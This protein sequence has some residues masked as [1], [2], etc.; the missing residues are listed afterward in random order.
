MD[1]LNRPPGPEPRRDYGAG[2]KSSAKRQAKTARA[3][4]PAQGPGDGMPAPDAVPFESILFLHPEKYADVHEAAEPECFPDLN[5]DQVVAS[6]VSG[7]EEYRLEGHFHTMLASVDEVAY[8]HEIVRDLGLAPPSAL[9]R[10]FAQAMH[11]MRELLAQADKL[12]F[13]LQKQSL[14]LMA[15]GTCCRAVSALADGLVRVDLGSRGMKAFRAYLRDYVASDRFSSLGATVE[16]LERDLAAIRYCVFIDG[17][18]FKVHKY[19]GEADY[20]AEIEKTFAKFRQGDVKD[21]RSKLQDYLSMSFVEEKILEFVSRLWPQVF[22]RLARFFAAG[23]DAFLD[24][25]IALFDRQ[26]QFYLAWLDHI[27]RLKAGGLSFC[28]PAVSDSDKAVEADD[29][30]DVALAAKLAQ[31]ARIVC[32]DFALFGKERILVV[33]GPNQGGKTTFSRTF[34]QM[35]YLASLGLPVP[36]REARLFLPDAV[37]THFE[38][39]EDIANL[40]GKLQDDL[41]RVHDILGRTTERSVVIMNEI[42]TSTTLQDATFLSEKV[43][44]RI[45]DLDILCV[46]VTFIHEL[47]TFSETTVSMVSTVDPANPDV[48]T[49]K[50][51]RKAASGRSY[52]MSIAEKYGLTEERLRERIRA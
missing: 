29:A 50:V 40:R 2:S 27:D 41:V 9:L 7:R 19:R 46:W 24:R 47:A 35:H 30:F 45:V 43:M 13:S 10:E 20:S 15:A 36:G 23:K 22:A 42:F 52:A 38:R 11:A 31:K 48:R 8:R 32:N 21:Y 18:S 17:G 3:D 33:S 12:H 39:E 49:Y 37:F 28:L 6:A 5:L 1:Q 51:V 14:F 44:R 16:T 26:I 34:G 25:K 4:I